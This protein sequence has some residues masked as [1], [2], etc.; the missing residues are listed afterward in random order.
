MKTKTFKNGPKKSQLTT[1]GNRNLLSQYIN[2]KPE[3]KSLRQLQQ[4]K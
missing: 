1:G 4:E 3:M 2:K